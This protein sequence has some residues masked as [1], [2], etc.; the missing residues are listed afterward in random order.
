MTAWTFEERNVRAGSDANVMLAAAPAESSRAQS[1]VCGAAI[2]DAESD[3][4]RQ[5]CNRFRR[6]RR[7]SVRRRAKAAWPRGRQLEP[8]AP[9]RA[10]ICESRSASSQPRHKSSS[11]RAAH[12]CRVSNLDAYLDDKRD[13][14]AD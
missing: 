7:L 4:R 9:Q 1:S 2:G 6:S 13:E 14:L 12:H 3:L 11:S 10:R 8:A 5:F